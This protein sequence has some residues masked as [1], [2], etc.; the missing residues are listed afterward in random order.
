MVLTREKIRKIKEDF[1]R[2]FD[3]A[4]S[5]LEELEKI[6]IKY[7]GRKSAF[8]QML[9]ELKDLSEDKKR[10]LGPLAN[11]VKKDIKNSIDEAILDIKREKDLQKEWIDVTAPGNKKRIGSLNILSQTQREIE[12]IFNSMGFEIAD[13]PEVESEWYNFD[14]LNMPP[15]H[16]ARDLWDTFWLKQKSKKDQGK[17]LLRTHTSNVQVRYM[18]KNKPPLKIVV[19]GKAYRYEATDANHEHS[20]AQ[21]EA[22]VAGDE[23]NV[24]NFK[25]VAEKFFSSYFRQDINVRLRPSYFPFTEPSFEFD[26]SCTVCEGGGCPAC[27]N[28]GWLEVGGCGMVNQRV[29]E[30]AGY[31]R[32]KYQGFAWGFGIERLAMMKHKI[33]DIRYFRSGDLRFIRQF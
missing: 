24:A 27:K 29:F 30:A 7:L 22:L 9:K 32:D 14:A 19:P 20:M 4:K 31:P 26:I 21:F 16:P 28:T 13:G 33:D 6:R 8:N 23:I 17:L 15:D 25:D 3:E 5:G 10:E 2:E 1:L 18:K 12:R 11:E